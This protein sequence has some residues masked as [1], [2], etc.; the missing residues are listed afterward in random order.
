MSEGLIYKETLVMRQFDN[1]NL[2][3]AK[4]PQLTCSLKPGPVF[5]KIAPIFYSYTKKLLFSQH[6]EGAFINMIMYSQPEVRKR[7]CLINL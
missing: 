3:A 4:I 7:S 2:M 1:E 5:R 6:E